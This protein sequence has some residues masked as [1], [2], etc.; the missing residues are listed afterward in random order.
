MEYALIKK[1]NLMVLTGEVGSGK[2]MLV[3]HFIERLDQHHVIRLHQTQLNEVE[4]LQLLLTEFGIEDYQSAKAALIAQIKQQLQECAKGDKKTIIIIDEAQNLETDILLILFELSQFKIKQKRTCLL[5]LIGQNELRE[6][7]DSADLRPV[8]QMI[9]CRYHLGSLNQ[10]EIKNYINHRLAIAGGHKTVS[11]DKEVFSVIETYTGGRPRL[12]NVLTDHILTYAYLESIREITTEVADAA[13]EDLQ[14]LP[15]GVQ[16]NDEIPKSNQTFLE[17]RRQSYKLV[18]KYDGEMQGD[19]YIN[20]RR[21]NI[22][23]HRSNDLRIDDPL[24]SRNHAQ[25][26]KHGR[27]IYLRDLGST[28][29]TYVNGKL[30]DIVPLE[31]GTKIRIGK[32]KMLFIR[33][34]DQSQSSDNHDGTL[35]DAVSIDMAATQY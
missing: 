20:T 18:I 32:C 34:N 26:I 9:N 23:R 11:F 19:Y 5:Y 14:W 16:Y 24:I 25:I 10:T 17:E 31:E 4:F 6:K 22:G 21:V 29:G 27:T 15:Y 7:L 33:H 30:I 8:I 3:Q 1:Q 28:N 35:N 12:I 13:I 2:T